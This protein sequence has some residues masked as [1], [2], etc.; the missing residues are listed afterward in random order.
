MAKEEKNVDYKNK[1]EYIST[2][3]GEIA[4]CEEYL[5]G[6]ETGEGK[7]YYVGDGGISMGLDGIKGG[8]QFLKENI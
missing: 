2:C 8:K 6:K 1:K 5:N 4:I 3:Y 7:I